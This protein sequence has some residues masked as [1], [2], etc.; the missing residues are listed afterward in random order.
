MTARPGGCQCGAIR[1]EAT[2]EPLDVGYCH[3]AICRK[4]SG[5]PV[6]LYA[7]YPA[8]AVRYLSGEPSIYR[9]SERGRRRFCPICGTHLEFRSLDAPDRVYLEATVF[10]R[11]DDLAP[12]RH[13]FHDSRPPWFE[14]A[15]DLPRHSGEGD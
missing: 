12:R 5:G 6:Q 4:L 15:D 1:L 7:E 3:C 9:S 8:G 13:I 11:L 14:I 10:D 2:G